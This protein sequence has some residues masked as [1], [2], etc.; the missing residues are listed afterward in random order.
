MTESNEDFD[1]EAWEYDDKVKDALNG[2]FEVLH[3]A[4]EPDNILYKCGV[5]NLKALK[6]SLI[7]LL[8]KDFN[9]HKLQE[10]LRKVEFNMKKTFFFKT[11]KKPKKKEKNTKERTT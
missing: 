3:L 2:L 8:N 1:E 9:P 4:L 5:D 11:P 10:S 7:D 6:T